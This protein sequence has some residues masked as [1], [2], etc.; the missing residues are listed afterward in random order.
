M[1]LQG[2][3]LLFLPPD[4]NW[5]SNFKFFLQKNKNTRR[6]E[7]CT[8]HYVEFPDRKKKR[9]VGRTARRKGYIFHTR[10]TKK[11]RT[12]H[13]FPSKT[14]FWADSFWPVDL[15]TSNFAFFFARLA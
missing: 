2:F 15:E 1:N 8:L 3:P 10:R 4:R 7:K 12:L 6:V 11:I 5:Q 14:F 9:N 13:N